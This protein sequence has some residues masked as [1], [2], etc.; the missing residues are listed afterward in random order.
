MLSI[1]EC[2]TQKSVCVCVD[3][4]FTHAHAFRFFFNVR[5]LHLFL[6]HLNQWSWTFFT[7]YRIS[8]HSIHFYYVWHQTLAYGVNEGFNIIS[9]I[10]VQKKKKCFHMQTN[11]I[12]EMCRF[13]LGPSFY[14][15][16]H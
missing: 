7:L 3:S 10:D 12:G 9:I 16:Q 4:G 8:R 5:P 14:A 15:A 6:D 11:A 1:T 2:G 13:T